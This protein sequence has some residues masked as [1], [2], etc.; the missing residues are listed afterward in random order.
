M[1]RLYSRAV[2]LRVA[3]LVVA[4]SLAACA[5]DLDQFTVGDGAMSEPCCTTTMDAPLGADDL[6]GVAPVDAPPCVTCPDGGFVNQGDMAVNSSCPLPQVLVAMDNYS[7]SGNNQGRVMRVSLGASPSKCS[8]LSGSKTL[9]NQLWS[10][11]KTPEGIAV[12]GDNALIVVNPVTD[13][14]VWNADYNLINCCVYNGNPSDLM[15]LTDSAGVHWLGVA[16]TQAGNSEVDYF[17]LFDSKGN[18]VHSW[19]LNQSNSPLL[20]GLGIRSFAINPRNPMNV[21]ALSEFDYAAEDVPVPFDNMPHNDT[22]YVKAY[23]PGG[24]VLKSIYATK[25]VGGVTTRVAWWQQDLNHT[26]GDAGWFVTDT[27]GGPAITGPL[28][29]ADPKCKQPNEMEHVVPDPTDVT[30]VIAI[31]T[32]ANGDNLRHVVRISPAGCTVLIDGT[33]LTPKYR[34]SALGIAQ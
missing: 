8:D 34:P 33:T 5:P 1:Q 28:R 27:G 25:D 18:M 16:F 32:D 14:I 2:S 20:L 29:C 24:G 17:Q 19:P 10:V 21:M 15:P 4:S 13:Q 6:T 3:L 26:A 7:G 12:G 23:P 31:C 9:P 22:V 30:A 11:A